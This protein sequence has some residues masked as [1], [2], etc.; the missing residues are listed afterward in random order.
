MSIFVLICGIIVFDLIIAT[1]DVVH[2]CKINKEYY[3]KIFYKIFTSVLN[4]N[5][6]SSKSFISEYVQAQIYRIDIRAIFDISFKNGAKICG[7]SIG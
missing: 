4:Y 7:G 1:N 6:P 5:G 2:L 3:I